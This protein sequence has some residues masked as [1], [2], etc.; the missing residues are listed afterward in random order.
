MT[1]V[2]LIFKD[3]EICLFTLCAIFI[4]RELVRKAIALYKAWQKSDKIRFIIIFIINSLG[5]LPIVYLIL[6][7]KKK[8]KN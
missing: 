8:G 2:W 4:I 6:N 7:K 5:I 3:E 1:T